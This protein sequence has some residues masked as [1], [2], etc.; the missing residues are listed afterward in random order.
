MKKLLMILALLCASM[1]VFGEKVSNQKQMANL[2]AFVGKAAAYYKANAVDPV[3]EKTVLDE[4]SDPKGPW[5]AGGFYLYVYDETGQCVAHG[6]NKALINKSLINLKADGVYFIKGII[7]SVKATGASGTTLDTA[8]RF[9]FANP[10]HQGKI[11]PKI[12]YNVL[13][14]YGTNRKLII[15]SGFYLPPTK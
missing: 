14:G 4:F 9:K 10:D 5:V 8:Y 1:L 11:E 15:G 12:S 6:A 13:V 7:E 3:S 2:T